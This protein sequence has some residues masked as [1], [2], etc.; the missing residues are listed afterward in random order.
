MSVNKS[1]TVLEQRSEMFALSAQHSITG[2]CTLDLLQ[3]LVEIDINH[4]ILR[5]ISNIIQLAHV[6]M[7]FPTFPTSD[8]LTQDIIEV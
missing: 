3:P 8:Q 5:G 1:T 4:V 7:Q 2:T 6:I